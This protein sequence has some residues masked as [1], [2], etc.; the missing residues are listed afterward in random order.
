[1]QKPGLAATATINGH[2]KTSSVPRLYAT[3]EAGSTESNLVGPSAPKMSLQ[4]S[5]SKTSK[6][7]RNAQSSGQMT[8]LVGSGVR[9]QQLPKM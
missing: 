3:K 9:K 8:T 4:K 5:P 1:M 2:N 7:M 6:H